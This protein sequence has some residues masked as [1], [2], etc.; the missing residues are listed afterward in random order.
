M[1]ARYRLTRGGGRGDTLY[2]VD[3]KTG[4][5]VSLQTADEAAGWQI[6]E[7][8][9]QA[10]RQ[11]MLNLQIAKAFLAGSDN[12]MSIRTWRHAIE[13]LTT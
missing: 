13:S 2:C 9:N 8:K 5:R 1:K 4:K 12:A 11:P 3:S 6:I 10:E 7:A